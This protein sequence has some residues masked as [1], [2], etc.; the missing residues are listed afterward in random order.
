[1]NDDSEVDGARGRVTLAVD[2]GAEKAIFSTEL[3]AR[4]GT[5]LRFIIKTGLLRH[6]W[7]LLIYHR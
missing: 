7:E 2:S 5:P 4:S 6:Q 1:M 3:S